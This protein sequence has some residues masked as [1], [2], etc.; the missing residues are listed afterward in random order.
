MDQEAKKFYQKTWFKGLVGV[1]ILFWVIS[2]ISS[3]DKPKDTAT[4]NT[5]EQQAKVEEELVKVKATELATAYDENEVAADIKYKGKKVEVSGS[6]KDIATVLGS[7]YVTL[8][9]NEILS[10]V[11][12]NFDKGT[13]S[14]L[15][16]LKKNAKI[17]LRGEVDGKSIFNVSVKHC[18]IVK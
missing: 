6:V 13:E 15:A 1:V 4:N 16:T 14:E 11:Q 5:P 10:D 7:S 3:D 17:I 8:M 12:C 9:G 2:T 18:V